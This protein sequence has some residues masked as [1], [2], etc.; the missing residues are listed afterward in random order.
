MNKKIVLFTTF[1][2]TAAL[3]TGCGSSGSAARNF[4]AAETAEQ[5]TVSETSALLTSAAGL[6][7]PA[8]GDAV[9]AGNTLGVE[10]DYT[11]Q[12]SDSGSNCNARGA[13][14]DGSTVTL[15][16][17]GTYL[18]SGS[19]TDGQLLIS[20]DSESKV[21]LLLNGV[22]VQN[23]S[24]AAVYLLN[25]DKL[26]LETVDGSSNYLA[27]SGAFDAVDGETVDAVIYAKDDLTLKGS[28]SL[29]VVTESGHGIVC[30][31]DL[32]ISGGTLNVSAARK[33]VYGK[34]SVTVS[35]CVLNLSAGT[36]GICSDMQGVA[37]SGIVTLES[38][39]INIVSGDKGISASV[40]L[41]VEE[42]EIVINA[43]ED[44]LHSD[45]AA[46]I[47]GGSILIDCRDDAVHA[48]S[49]LSVGGG[50]LEISSCYEGLEAADLTIS[51]GTVTLN[52]SDDGVNAGRSLTVTGGSMI[53]NASGDGVDSN[54][55]LTVTGGLLYISGP[56]NSGN[57]AL[58][59]GTEGVISGG[60]VVACGASGMAVN[61][62]S[63][64][65]QGSILYNFDTSLNGGDTVTLTNAAG[66][67]LASFTPEKAYNSVVIS[68]PGIE[69][70][71]TYTLT[72]GS[73]SVSIEMT[74]LIYGSGGMGGHGG[75]GGGMGG[76]GGMNG[77]MGGHESV[78]GSESASDFGGHGGHGGFDPNSMPDSASESSD[79]G[80]APGRPDGS[81]L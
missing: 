57:G 5:F 7:L 50:S 51:G 78:D 18:V 64:S 47:N 60:I 31:D 44:G 81:A 72:A 34:D 37:E 52:A 40:L 54:G 35:D 76:H 8:F 43:G 38:G 59:Y 32:K 33:A 49:S 17:A 48:D 79:P 63:N 23:S 10:Y 74:S 19:L 61:F 69:A 30:K 20:T 56:T 1:L 45:A 9:S 28:G 29:T 73:Q 2:L 41:T 27:G 53:I 22:S 25:A 6:S 11:L 3:L 67:I 75:M 4:S 16:E 39:T 13:V 24:T 77:G 70:G 71:S 66:E 68:A 65:T 58:D 46:V 14:I 15:T 26:V 55:S 21:K 12:L 80:N 42:P 36:T 62:G